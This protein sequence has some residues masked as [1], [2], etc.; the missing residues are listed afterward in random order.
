MNL[1]LPFFYLYCINN[2]CSI[3]IY[4]KSGYIEIPFTAENIVATHF[5]SCCQKQLVSAMDVEIEQLTACT[6]VKLLYK[7]NY[8]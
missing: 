3:S 5:C 1:S 2:K 6:D 8:N 7:L 4:N